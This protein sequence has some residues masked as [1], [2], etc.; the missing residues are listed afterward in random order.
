[1]NISIYP[2]PPECKMYFVTKCPS[3]ATPIYGPAIILSRWGLPLLYLYPSSM[4]A[5]SKAGPTKAK[6][7]KNIIPYMGVGLA[8][9]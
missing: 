8:K 2:I 1:M 3:I 4:V 6:K 9:K 7:T 5:V